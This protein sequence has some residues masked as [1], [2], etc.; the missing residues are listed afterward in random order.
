MITHIL[1]I[2]IN[3]SAMNTMVNTESRYPSTKDW[4]D[5][6][7]KSGVWKTSNILDTM[8]ATMMKLLKVLLSLISVHHLLNQLSLSKMK[9]ELTRILFQICMSSEISSTVFFC[10]AALSFKA[11]SLKSLT[12]LSTLVVWCGMSSMMSYMSL[13]LRMRSSFA[14]SKSVLRV[15][16]LLSN[17]S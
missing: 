7:S 4:L 1:I 5:V 15:R 9:K 14:S 13:F 8:I 16:V 12:V 3:I 6:G 17:C 2:L 11:K 10:L